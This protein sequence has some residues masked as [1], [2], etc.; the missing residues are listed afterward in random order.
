MWLAVSRRLSINTN[1]LRYNEKMETYKRF[2]PLDQYVNFPPNFPRHTRHSQLL[3]NGMP[4]DSNVRLIILQLN[5][6][7]DISTHRTIFDDTLFDTTQSYATEPYH[8]NSSKHVGVHPFDAPGLLLREPRNLCQEIALPVHCI[9]S[10]KTPPIQCYIL[11][12]ILATELCT[13]RSE[14][15][16]R[17]R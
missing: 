3:Y 9:S 4:I 7:S 13:R 6:Y 5:L 1:A 8:H 11:N 12:A 17:E 16:S 14:R 10:S 2:Q 15:A